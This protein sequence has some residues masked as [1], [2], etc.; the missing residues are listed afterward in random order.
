[1]SSTP[2][3]VP[4]PIP[5]KKKLHV[6]IRDAFDDSELESSDFLLGQLDTLEKN[7]TDIV[8]AV[9]ARSGAAV[10]V[11][12]VERIPEARA[13]CLRTGVTLS[14]IPRC[15]QYDTDYFEPI[16][17]FADAADM[18]WLTQWNRGHAFVQITVENLEQ[19]FGVLEFIVKDS[20]S[21]E[22]PKLSRVMLLLPEEA[23]PLAVV[24]AIYGHWVE[25]ATTKIN[26][27]ILKYREHPPD[28]WGFRAKLQSLNRQIVKQRKSLTDW[29]YIRK[30]NERLKEVR[31]ERQK[32]VE[33]LQRQKEGQVGDERF[34]RKMIKQMQRAGSTCGMMI[35]PPMRACERVEVPQPEE[36]MRATLPGPPTAPRFLKWCASEM[37]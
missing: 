27:S 19:V 26:G 9:E 24:S 36:G 20:C 1:M 29:D 17:Y 31:S 15:F 14:R 34:V 25:R 33:L 32:A 4:L 13:D 12:E 23:P 11:P 30:L 2:E 37:R 3:T 6:L 16:H 21:S 35:P 22:D 5:P 10:P 8:R 28:H 18:A 7:E